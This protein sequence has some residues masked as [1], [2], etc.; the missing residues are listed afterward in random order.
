MNIL[1]DNSKEFAAA[2]LSGVILADPWGE[3]WNYGDSQKLR[4]LLQNYF[5]S[6]FFEFPPVVRSM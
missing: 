3:S 6:Y 4:S 1:A 2:A 5:I